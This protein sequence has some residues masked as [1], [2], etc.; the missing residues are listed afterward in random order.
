MGMGQE[1]KSSQINGGARAVI[2]GLIG[3]NIFSLFVAGLYEY[4]ALRG[5]TN[6]TAA[7]IVL[8]VTWVVG[9]I[10]ICLSESV[11]GRTMKER[12]WTGALAAVILGGLL[13]ALNG[14]V[15]QITASAQT[16]NPDIG[17]HGDCNAIGSNNYIN[18]DPQKPSVQVP[19]QPRGPTAIYISPN[20]SIGHLYMEGGTIIGYPTVIDNEGTIGASDLKNN[21]MFLAPAIRSPD[22]P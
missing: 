6:M 13:L 10:G 22:K 8:L 18:C 19:T 11:W 21:K 16:V 17:L 14:W 12:M 9:V 1:E 3:S 4:L 5:V 2:L 15:D 7:W 20:A